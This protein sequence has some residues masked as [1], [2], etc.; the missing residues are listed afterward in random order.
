[1]STIVAL[2]TPPGRGA[3]AI[4]R[5]SGPQS[6]SI[7]QRLLKS[8]SALEP[9]KATL[10][11]IFKIDSD[12][13]LDQVLITTFPGPQSF[14]GEDVVEISCHGSPAVI[15]Q[16]LDLTLHHGARLAGPGE[17]TLRAVASGR[18]NLAQAEAVRD[19]INAQT[20][21]AA[22]QAARQMNGELSNILTPL[23]DRIVEVVVQLESALEFVEDDL[24]TVK[25]MALQE[26]L[27]GVADGIERLVLSY[28]SGRLLGLGAKVTILG[29]PN[30]GKSSIFNELVRV[31]R[32]IVT[33]KP[34]T[35]RDTLTETIDLKGV[36][37]V[38]TDTA[39]L[40][41]TTDVVESMGIERT[42]RAM[43]DADLLL[44]VLDSTEPIGKAEE[45]L[46]AQT[47]TLPRL[48]VSNKSDLERNSGNSLQGLRISART[49]EGIEDLRLAILASLQ[50]GSRDDG[51]LLVTNARHHDVLVRA[52]REV[53]LAIN[54]LGDK[55]SEE[56]ILVPLHSALKL[57]GEITGE[58]TTE[59]ILSEIFAT[60]CIG[61]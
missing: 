59:N 55:L 40:R 12:E 30:V 58:T 46:L 17:F 57:L 11:K 31:D 51:T 54:S 28:K 38:L 50:D 2:S 16:L 48:V 14:T 3:V 61:K 49:G 42:Q 32:A 8:D 9:R 44:V 39:G 22:K 33:D 26:A 34:G 43:A 1:M 36:P 23:K 20:E 7:V 25:T 21:V 56:L 4:I 27:S 52:G 19:L 15:R 47:S 5:L 24:P 10:R 18:M 13:L 35:T 53:D 41:E 29:S 6:L 60:F 37:L 45:E